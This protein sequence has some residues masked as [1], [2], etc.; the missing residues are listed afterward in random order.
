MAQFCAKTFAPRAAS[1]VKVRAGRKSSIT[2]CRLA[3]AV[4][5]RSRLASACTRG[6]ACCS[7]RWR[8]AASNSGAAIRP[9]STSFSS[10]NAQ[11]S[12]PSIASATASRISGEWD[13]HRFSSVSGT[14]CP[15]VRAMAATAAR[16]SDEGV[17]GDS[18]ASSRLTSSATCSGSRPSSATAAARASGG[19]AVS[20]A[21]LRAA[22][23]TVPAEPRVFDSAS[24]FPAVNCRRDDLWRTRLSTNRPKASICAAEYRSS[25]AVRTGASSFAMPSRSLR[26]R[27]MSSRSRKRARPGRPSCPRRPTRGRRSAW[28]PNS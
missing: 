6:D 13:G 10:S 25:C 28:G 11:G 20:P 18:S 15:P 26:A 14:P 8:R 3:S 24:S 27:A 9:A 7:S 21:D 23:K 12:R 22:S 5:P 2:F 4:L 19:M 17:C 1:P 16:W